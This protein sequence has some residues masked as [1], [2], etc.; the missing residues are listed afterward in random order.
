MLAPA[1]SKKKAGRN[2]ASRI[3]TQTDANADGKTGTPTGIRQAR[4]EGFNWQGRFA[5]FQLGAPIAVIVNLL[6]LS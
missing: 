5:N 1:P 2:E 6:V 4:A 3:A